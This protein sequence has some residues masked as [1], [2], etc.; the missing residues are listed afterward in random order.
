VAREDPGDAI[1][2]RILHIGKFFPPT[3]G[4]MERFLG[5]LVK[6]QRDAGHEA[7]VLVH[8]DGRQLPGG[9]PDWVMR[10]PVWL[11]IAFAPISPG[12]LS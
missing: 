8:D 6:A 4:G 7:A 9:D 5:D 10:C 12:F 3:P 2:M 1:A 11:S